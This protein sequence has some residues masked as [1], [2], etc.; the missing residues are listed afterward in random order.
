MDE[1]LSYSLVAQWAFPGL[2]Y[3]ILDIAVGRTR[4]H[5]PVHSRMQSKQNSWEQV[6][7]R[8]RSEKAVRQMGHES[9]SSRGSSLGVLDIASRRAKTSH[10]RHFL[11]HSRI[12]QLVS[13]LDVLRST[14]PAEDLAP[15]SNAPISVPKASPCLWNL[16]LNLRTGPDQHNL[17][18]YWCG[19]H[20]CLPF[21]EH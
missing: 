19:L 8:V 5:G 20:F 11:R 21:P 14:E 13:L 17:E 7:T 10:F 16:R 18:R 4:E 9:M 15:P 3:G 2:N 1:M 6:G 12:F